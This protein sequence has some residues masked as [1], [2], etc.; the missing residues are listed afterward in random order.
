MDIDRIKDHW[1]VRQKCIKYI[2]IFTNRFLFTG[3]EYQIGT[4]IRYIS[5]IEIPRSIFLFL[6]EIEIAHAEENSYFPANF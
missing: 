1:Y 3:S 4:I 6:L 2:I 5:L